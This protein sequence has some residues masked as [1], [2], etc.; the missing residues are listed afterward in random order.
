MGWRLAI[1]AYRRAFVAIVLCVYAGGDGKLIVACVC[2][3]VAAG[4]LVLLAALEAMMTHT[5]WAVIDLLSVRSF[6]SSVRSRTK[7]VSISSSPS[8][9][10][11]FF[12][13]SV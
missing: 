6:V 12:S 7:V 1:T 4:A 11:F 8:F 2:A 5:F 13:P 10:P 9:F 3:I